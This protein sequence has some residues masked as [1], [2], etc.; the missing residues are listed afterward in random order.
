M[1]PS[2]SLLRVASNAIAKGPTWGAGTLVKVATG[3]AFV[4]VSAA[5]VPDD[6]PGMK[7]AVLSVKTTLLMVKS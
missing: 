2:E 6:I 1:V 7:L 4:M 3:G 5:P